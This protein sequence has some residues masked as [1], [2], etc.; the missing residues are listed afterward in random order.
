MIIL[1]KLKKVFSDMNSNLENRAYRTAITVAIIVTSLGVLT[2]YIYA[3]SVTS[4]KSRE[5][6][7]FQEEK[8]DYIEGQILTR[9]AT[10]EQ[11]LIAGATIHKMNN[12]ITKSDWRNAYYNLQ[13]P[14]KAPELLGY[15]YVEYVKR[16]DLTK[17]IEQAKQSVDNDYAVTPTGDREEYAP[18]KFVEPLDDTNASALGFDMYSD[19]SRYEAMLIARDSGEPAL[20]VPLINIQDQRNPQPV[21]PQSFL[22]Y[23]PVYE[24]DRVD[25]SDVR[26]LVGYSYVVFRINDIMQS[27]N[28]D[29]AKTISSLY[30]LDIGQEGVREL[31]SK[32]ANNNISDSERPKVYERNLDVLSRKWTLGMTVRQVEGSTIFN[33]TTVFIIGVFVSVLFGALL[34]LLLLKRNSDSNRNHAVDIQRTKDELLALASHQL[35]TPATG[36][37]QYVG[38]LVQGYFGTLDKEQLSIAKKAYDANERQIEIIDQLLYVAKADAGQLVISIGTVDIAKITCDVI[39]SYESVA[40]GKNIGLSYKGRK[41]LLCS[42]DKRYIIMIVENLIS[43]A[44]K[45]SYPD[46]DVIL[47]L[48]KVDTN[49]ILKV[50]DQG[51]GIA[52]EDKDKLFHKFSRIDSPLSRSEGGSGLGLFLAQKLAESHGGEIIAKSNG[53]KGS[54]FILKLPIKGD[55]KK[56]VVQLT[57]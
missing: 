57:V 29:W 21:Q 10:Y 55:K 35:R 48:K 15:G 23:Y 31:Y 16:D 39:A 7:S 24:E 28:I 46:S 36:V 6:D 33:L 56:S 50:K 41:K 40:A 2:A 8:A 47:E 9:L 13:I 49:M 53:K 1:T 4:E 51:I 45:Y 26:T 43:N 30:L 44:I 5:R 38:M 17:Y 32:D 42:G 52:E 25:I 37:R 27:I 20:T 19:P 22:M 54:I 3:G 12:N 34:F 18:I 14:E 11:L